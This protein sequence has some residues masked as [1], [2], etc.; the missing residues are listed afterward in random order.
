M[1]RPRQRAMPNRWN[2][3]VSSGIEDI[4]SFYSLWSMIG[5]LSL[6]MILLFYIHQL[7]FDLFALENK[8]F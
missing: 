6:K 1:I 2:K 7:L 3:A 4:S 5:K 8:K